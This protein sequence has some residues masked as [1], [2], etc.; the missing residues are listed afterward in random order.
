[1]SNYWSGSRR[2]CRICCVAHVHWSV[3][4]R[5]TTRTRR[6]KKSDKICALHTRITRLL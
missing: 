3:Q 2:V 5:C 1:L 6:Q 4:Q